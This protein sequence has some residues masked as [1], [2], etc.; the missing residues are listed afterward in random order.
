MEIKLPQFLAARSTII[1]QNHAACINEQFSN[2]TEQGYLQMIQMKVASQATSPAK[3]Q[4][5]MELLLI[6]VVERVLRGSP[7]VS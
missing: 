2:I 5:S 1:V 7:T 4:E 3:G 6:M